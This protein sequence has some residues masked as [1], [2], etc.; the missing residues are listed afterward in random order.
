MF[1]DIETEQRELK[2]IRKSLKELDAKHIYIITYD[3]EKSVT[4]MGRNIEVIPI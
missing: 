3:E 1:S 2:A 4:L